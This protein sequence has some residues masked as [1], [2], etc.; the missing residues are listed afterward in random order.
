MLANRNN[1]TAEFSLW[2]KL[3]V[4]GGAAG[5]F[6]GLEAG[7]E[8]FFA[9]GAGA[10]GPVFRTDGAAGHFLDVVVADGGGGFQCLGDVALGD[11]A[12]LLGGVAPDAG[13]AVGLQLEID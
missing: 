12:A 11:F 7:G 10:V 8:P 6:A 1:T 4:E 2:C 3:A 5:S 9:L 13:E